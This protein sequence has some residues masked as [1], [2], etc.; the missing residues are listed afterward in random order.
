MFRR[1]P[2]LHA[3]AA[4]EAAARYLSFARAADELCLTHSA[5]SHRIR[6][7]E[8]HLGTRLFLRLNRHIALTPQGESF[9]RVVR[10]ALAKLQEGAAGLVEGRTI[11]LR[12]SVLPAFASYWLIQ[13][14]A[15]FHARHPDI[16]LEVETTPLLANLKAGE[17]QVGIRLGEG[18]Y[19]G[20]EAHQL[21]ADEIFPVASPAYLQRFGPMREPRALEGAVLLRNRRVPWRPWFAA[22]GLDW[23]E[24]AAGPMYGDGG[25]MLDAAVGGQGVALGRTSLVAE[26]V[27]HGALVRVG[28]VAAPAPANF[29]AV[30]LP[31]SAARPEVAAFMAWLQERAAR[32]RTEC[33]GK[34]LSR[35]A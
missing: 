15:D 12:I 10:E 35:V 1:M 6:Q 34:P 32:W 24:P 30:H 16:E 29:F 3:L 2:P 26:A 7:L 11:H 21:F 5:V 19:P 4:F 13:R 9:L 27:R 18:G 17:V 20:L 14:V 22:A 23:P 25:F 8:S 31:E 28:G 33:A